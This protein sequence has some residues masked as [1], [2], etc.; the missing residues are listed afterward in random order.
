VTERLGF[1]DPCNPE[2]L[3]RLDRLRRRVLHTLEDDQAV[4][5]CDDTIVQ[6]LK[7]LANTKAMY[8]GLNQPAWTTAIA[9]LNAL[10]YSPS[11]DGRSVAAQKHGHAAGLRSR[12]RDFQ[13]SRWQGF[14]LSVLPLAAPGEK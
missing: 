4:A 6:N 13:G 8:L 3:Q 12:S 11:K 9:P 7:P 2:T 10:A 5:G 14:A 1:L